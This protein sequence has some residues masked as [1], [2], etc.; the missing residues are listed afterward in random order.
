VRR[1]ALRA[2]VLA[3][4]AIVAACGGGEPARR[5]EEV[6]ADGRPR[7]IV[8]VVIDTLRR[9]HVS[10]YGGRV[11]TPNIDRLAAEGT[12]VDGAVSSFHQT[13]MSMA[14]LFTG[15]TPSL[16]SGDLQRPLGWTGRTWC[17]MA[18]FD[19]ESE[20]LAEREGGESEALA[21]RGGGS[22][23]VPADLPTLAETLRRDGYRTVGIVSNP[24]LFEP[25][26]YARGFDD[27]VQVGS[28][29][30]DGD[31]DPSRAELRS[32]AAPSVLSAAEAA[33]HRAGD[34]ALFL[35]VHLMDVHDYF[36]GTDYA[37][38][39]VVADEAVGRLRALLAADGGLDD[40]VIVLTADHGERLGEEHVVAGMRAHY[41]NPSFET[42]LDVP[43]VVWP[44]LE[45]AL[46]GLVRGEDVYDLVLA[47]AGATSSR[48]PVLEPDEQLV[49][50]Q[51]FVTYRRGRWK[52][53]FRR[54]DDSITLVD[55][56]Q[57]PGEQRD[58]AA[59]HPDVVAAHRARITALGQAL[60]AKTA[61]LAPLSEDDRRRLRA[62]GYVQ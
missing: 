15:R 26:G 54:G 4:L 44:R 2:S 57:D 22:Q 33:L 20:A 39:V 60:A 27:W 12:R 11:Q 40:T 46:P 51:R 18:R 52:S 14:A 5:H 61:D 16:E 35:Y 36:G 43:L 29:P 47:L 1:L 48:Q 28:M 37:D 31:L 38:A 45:R 8:L 13:T 6:A 34:R 9:D 62:L 55:L 32:R 49:S 53:F 59:E 25:A 23:C 3:A 21:E 42:V 58:V 30:S 19:D 7:R 24:L 41:G 50:E 17:G 56:E 10:A